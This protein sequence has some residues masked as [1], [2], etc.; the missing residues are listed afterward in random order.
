MFWDGTTIGDATV[1]PYDSHTEFAQVMR[2]V[3]GDNQMPNLGGVCRGVGNELA[4]TIAGAVSPVNINTGEGVVHGTFYQ[5]TASVAIAI[6]NSVASRYDRIVLRKDWGAQTVRL[7]R[8]A[9]AEGGGTPALVQVLGTT[10]DVPICTVRIQVAALTLTSD[11][12][13]YTPYRVPELIARQGG[14]AT[15]WDIAGVVTYTPTQAKI[16]CGTFQMDLAPGGDT[17]TFPVAFTG[18]PVVIV[19][20]STAVSTGD[21]CVINVGA[22]NN[23]NFAVVAVNLASATADPTVY[24]MAIGI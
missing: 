10:W 20:C 17:I 6:P 4:P 12:R 7:T 21:K 15:N 1:A 24:W 18:A 19:S 11:D 13:E 2:A 16:Q 5:N 3:S 14:H 8:I 22:V 9:G 23:N